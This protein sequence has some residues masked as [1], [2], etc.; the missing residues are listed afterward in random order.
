MRKA[1]AAAAALV[2]VVVIGFVF[3][4]ATLFGKPPNPCSVAS[5]PGGG[6]QQVSQTGP[7]GLDGNNPPLFDEVDRLSKGN[8]RLI[9]GMYFG[10]YIESRRNNNASNGFAFGVFQIEQPG[11]VRKGVTV[12]QAKDPVFAA[13]FMFPEYKAALAKVNPK[14]WQIDPMLA[15]EQ[16]AYMAE[17]PARLY[18][19][20]RGIATVIEAW[21]NTLAYMK[22]RGI[23]TDFSVDPT[24]SAAQPAPAAQ[25]QSQATPAMTPQEAIDKFGLGPV[26]PQLASLVSEVA[27]RYGITTA[28]G[29]ST[30]ETDSK[31]HPDG[32]AADLMTSTEQGNQ[33]ADYLMANADRL[34]V[35]YVIWRQRIW[36]ASQ[37]AAGWTQVADRGSPTQNYMDHVHVS[38]TRAPS[39]N[40]G[41]PP[42]IPAGQVGG[43]PAVQDCSAVQLAAAGAPVGQPGVVSGTAQEL[44]R[45]ILALPRDRIQFIF[46]SDA[47]LRATADG[48]R[49]VAGPTETC[50][51]NRPVA[52]SPELLQLILDITKQYSITLGSVNRDRGCDGGRHPIGRAADINFINGVQITGGEL[53]FNP[54]SQKLYREFMDYVASVLPRGTWANGKPVGMGGMGE[55]QCFPTPYPE[56]DGRNVFPD[57]C[58][59]IHVDVGVAAA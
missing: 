38:V 39:P 55:Q 2:L 45:Q 3:T 34:S 56:L 13:E 25:P 22:A 31:G 49:P 36:F 8:N 57:A 48:T 12:A 37:P 59:H 58:T 54:G 15:A 27:P 53:A 33:V 5:N 20:S 40:A 16:T 47:D 23:S 32:L 50:P 17:K 29:T 21:N 14:I 52:L 18:R 51:S 10:S 4:F 24:G 19:D 44:A 28:S 41:L 6:A 26:K 42:V 11:V 43:V 9:M 7:N 35:D 30:Q 46:G 1:L